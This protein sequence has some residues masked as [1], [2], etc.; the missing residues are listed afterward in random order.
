MLAIS[1]MFGGCASAPSQRASEWVRPRRVVRAPIE[2]QV[3][4]GERNGAVT[5]VW[6]RQAAPI[7]A[8]QLE[9]AVELNTP[10]RPV[11]YSYRKIDV[12]CSERTF[13]AHRPAS[14]S[15]GDWHPELPYLHKARFGSVEAEVIETV[16]GPKHVARRSGRGWL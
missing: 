3:G 4:K 15:P 9:R 2:I 12:D 6:T 10:L 7:D 16:C 14:W 1:M 13:F 11:P 8:V 5:S